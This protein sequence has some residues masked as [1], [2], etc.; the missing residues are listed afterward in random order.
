MVGKQ[1]MEWHCFLRDSHKTRWNGDGFAWSNDSL[2]TVHRPGLHITDV[3]ISLLTDLPQLSLNGLN[4]II[5]RG[6]VVHAG[7]DDMGRVRQI[8]NF[9][10]YFSLCDMHVFKEILR[11]EMMAVW[12]RG[13]RGD[14][15]GAGWWPGQTRFF[16]FQMLQTSFSRWIGIIDDY[17]NWNLR[18]MGGDYKKGHSYQELRWDCFHDVDHQPFVTLSKMSQLYYMQ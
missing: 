4:S 12:K 14:E 9:Y 2:V 16:Q 8:T 17:Y 10:F 3:L 13:T 5:G 15:L 1:P 7:R 6:V 18:K 11:A